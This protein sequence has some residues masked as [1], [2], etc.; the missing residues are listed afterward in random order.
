MRIA[1][2]QIRAENRYYAQVPHF[3]IW[4]YTPANLPSWRTLGRRRV[5][6]DPVGYAPV[7]T[8]IPKALRQDIDVLIYGSSG[9][10]RLFHALAQRGLSTVFVSGL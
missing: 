6:I 10:R 9:E 7:L 2:A 3:E 4:E 1:A 5:K 8:R